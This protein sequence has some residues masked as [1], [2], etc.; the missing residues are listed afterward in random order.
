MLVD[1]L[2][3]GHFDLF[4]KVFL[5]EIEM[6]VLWKELFL[7]FISTH[8]SNYNGLTSD[9]NADELKFSLL[10]VYVYWRIR[11]F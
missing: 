10:F 3:V 9:Y 2:E 11:N 1:G 6:G 4:G 8:L 7:P 5:I